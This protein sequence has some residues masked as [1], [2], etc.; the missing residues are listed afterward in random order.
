MQGD[1]AEDL[2]SNLALWAAKA[3][4]IFTWD[5]GSNT[6][7]A[8]AVVSGFFDLDADRAMEGLPLQDYLARMHPGDKPR[9]ARAIHAAILSGEPY[10]QEYRLVRR[11]GDATWVLAIGHCFR[12]RQGAPSIYAGVIYDIT[13][14][15]TSPTDGLSD[16][17]HAA[18]HVAE[19]LGNR[20]LVALLEQAVEEASG[21]GL[22]QVLR[23]S[24]RH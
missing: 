10:Q 6:L 5:I 9:V 11:E 16:H 21:E 24:I 7:Y 13:E 2:N 14:Q 3:A 23:K 12:N 17:C 18:L 4:G 8:D 19:R 15:K 20:R 22:R 1:D